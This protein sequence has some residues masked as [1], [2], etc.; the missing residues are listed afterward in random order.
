MTRAVGLP[1][2]WVLA[3]AAAQ[4]CDFAGDR[5]LGTVALPSR[6]ETTE[7]TGGSGSQGGSESG[8]SIKLAGGSES[9]GADANSEIVVE[10]PSEK[11]CVP[12]QATSC[13]DHHYCDLGPRCQFE[14][15]CQERPVQ[16][17]DESEARTVCGC[18]GK[19]YQSLCQAR[20]QGVAGAA[21]EFCDP[22]SCLQADDCAEFAAGCVD[23]FG[24][25]ASGAECINAHCQCAI[26]MLVL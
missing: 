15:S 5:S 16:C 6:S 26:E 2:G 22:M 19:F 13:P 3:L 17:P 18:D 14:G 24:G 9:G 20:Q 25:M 11:S 23:V 12:E 10:S 4:A 21:L 7:S 1:F 8:G